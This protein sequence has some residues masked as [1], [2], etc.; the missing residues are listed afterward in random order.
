MWN[1]CFCM[2]TKLNFDDRLIRA[3]NVRAAHD[4][5]TLTA[6]IE[7]ALRAYLCVPRGS[8]RPFRAELLI[9]GDGRSLEWN[10]TT[11]TC[12]M[13]AWTGALDRGRHQHSRRDAPRG[14]DKARPRLHRAMP[15]AESPARSCRCFSSASSS[16]S[17][18][19][20]GCWI[21]RT[22]PPM[23]GSL[24]ISASAR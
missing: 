20:R 9:R 21:H 3:T 18:P 17:S 16:A 13:S 1:I 7:R 12:S 6:L 14:V 2:E 24:R 15:I 5:D 8:K 19:I 22:R 23:R 4:D 11:G 10:R